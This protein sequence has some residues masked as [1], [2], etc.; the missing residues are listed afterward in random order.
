ME[1]PPGVP[2]AGLALEG[3]LHV[4]PHILLH[5]GGSVCGKVDLVPGSPLPL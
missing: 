1:G 3:V 2:E 5:A 4:C